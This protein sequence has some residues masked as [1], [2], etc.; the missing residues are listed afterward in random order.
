MTCQAC[1]TESAAGRKFCDECGAALSAACPACGASN[2]PGAKFCGECATPLAGAAPSPTTASTPVL[3]ERATAERRLVTVL[4][5]DLVGFTT[6][7]EGRDAEAVRD[8]LSEYF[9]LASDLLGRYGGT[10]EKFIGDAVMAV[11][12][13]PIAHE[14]DAERAVR[15][16]LE[17]A[18][19]VRRLGPDIAARVGVVTGEAAVTI[20]ATNQ[21]MVAGDLVN[22]ASRLQSVAQPGTVLIG[23]STQRAV[24]AAIVCEPAGDQELKGKALPVP[25]W[26]AMRVV[27]ERGGTG[28]SERLE[29]PFVGR[30][31]ELRLLKELLHATGREGRPRLVSVIGQAGIGKS[32][33]VWELLKYIDGLVED[34]YWHDGRSPAYGEGVTFWALGE[35]VR[36]RAGLAETDDEATVRLGIAAMLEEYVPDADERRWIEPSL[37]ALLGIADAPRSGGQ[38]LFAAWRAF[39]ERISIKGTVA[40]VFEDVHWADPGLLD[41]VDHLVEWSRAP[42]FV[43]TLARPEL[44]D[45]RP[46]WGSGARSFTSLHLDPLTDAAMTDLL[47]GLVPGL[48]AAVGHAIVAR[49]EGIPLYAVETVRMLVT[50]GRLVE[51]EGSYS[52]AGDLATLAVPD[53]LHALIAARLDALEPNDRA[54]LQDAAVLGQSFTVAALA[55]V[56]GTDASDLEPRLRVLVRRELLVLEVDPRS[57]ERGQYAFVQALIREVSY[58]TLARRGRRSRHLAAARYFEGL[59]DDELAGVLA[60][61]YLAAHAESADGAE[62]DALAA[63]ARIALKGAAE[64]AAQLGSHV[65][66]IAFLEGALS[67]TADRGEEAELLR[68]LGVASSHAGRHDAA[69]AFLGRALAAY[70]D[71]GDREGAAGAVS[72][73][74]EVRLNAFQLQPALD[75]LEPAAKEFGDL[76]DSALVHLWSQLARARFFLGQTDLAVEWSDRTLAAAERLNVIPIVADTLA[77]KGTTLAEAGRPIEGS[78][79]LQAALRLAEANALQFTAGRAHLNLS[80]MLAEVDPAAG[81]ASARA[82][83]AHVRRYGAESLGSTLVANFATTALRFGLWDAVQEEVTAETEREQDPV[84]RLTVLVYKAQISAMRGDP[85]EATLEECRR[86]AAGQSDPQLHGELHATEAVVALAGGQLAEAVA[87]GMQAAN[88]MSQNAPYGFRVAGRAALWDGNVD[89]ARDALRGLEGIAIHGP[90]MEASRLTVRAGIAA[91]EGRQSEALGDYREALRLWRDVGLLWDEALCGL[92]F[93][94]LVGMRDDEARATVERTAEILTQL[95]ARPFLA[96]LEAVLGSS[97]PRAATATLS[98]EEPASGSLREVVGRS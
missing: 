29:A 81:L 86:M 18:D 80:Y 23:E 65:Q 28:R 90:H 82:G 79:L 57:P 85:I 8:L 26:R 52:P 59:G 75:V 6:L 64:R 44:M 5:A 25:A 21:G 48:S 42:I 53:S 76:P 22:T 98:S 19:A 66:E 17:L 61:H 72:L 49:A 54:L 20:G 63:Q 92:D 12:G 68:R 34:I 35:M 1:G 40:L 73:Q 69:D 43:V 88:D 46:T 97:A 15:A 60:A 13:T 55:A 39:F 94:I 96:R 38:E 32:R 30:D 83:L 36:V 41:F 67:I 50:E 24:S 3:A 77:T 9:D 33:L 95:G 45:K 71:L 74:G 93:A 78:G 70:R 27:A 89:A 47:D 11:W 51:S 16:A 10:V 84:D 58:A 62:A 4:F 7:A 31:D 14:D 56:S 87:K 91:V 37:L 2:R